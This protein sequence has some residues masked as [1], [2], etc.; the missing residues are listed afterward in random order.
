MSTLDAPPPNQPPPAY[1][2]HSYDD[3]LG[4]GDFDGPAPGSLQATAAL[5]APLAGAGGLGSIGLA[6]QPPG[7]DLPTLEMTDEIWDPKE[8]SRREAAL[9]TRLQPRKSPSHHPYPLL[10]DYSCA[11]SR[12]SEVFVLTAERPGL[13]RVFYKPKEDLVRRLEDAGAS[14]EEAQHAAMRMRSESACLDY[15][16]ALHERQRLRDIK[17][18]LEEKIRF[19]RDQEY[20]C[21]NKEAIDALR[22]YPD[23]KEALLYIRHKRHTRLDPGCAQCVR[24]FEAERQG[25]Q[26]AAAAWERR[27]AQMGP[28]ERERYLNTLRR[29]SQR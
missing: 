14:S 7:R 16:D 24:I 20:A 13:L 23:P 11:P 3:R 29:P 17:A 6:D 28:M 1:S 10:P 4:L 2:R 22:W 5:R 15:I 8:A 27:V 21:S 18:Q 25:D 9:Y 19:I 12:P 26:A